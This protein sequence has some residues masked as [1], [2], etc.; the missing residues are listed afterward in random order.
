MW[1]SGLLLGDPLHSGQYL[2]PVF[3]KSSSI[4]PFLF[5]FFL[6]LNQFLLVLLWKT[7]DLFLLVPS[8]SASFPLLSE[9]ANRWDKVAVA[10][11]VVGVERV[12]FLPFDPF[13]SGQEDTNS[14]QMTIRAHLESSWLSVV[15]EYPRTKCDQPSFVHRLW[16]VVSLNNFPPTP[17]S[18]LNGWF[19]EWL[20]KQGGKK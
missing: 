14:A 20:C 6:S 12:V 15:H 1:T 4:F 10:V 19:K 11:V 8:A 13:R 18:P 2:D 17:S 7:C 16:S 9:L 5:S 3:P